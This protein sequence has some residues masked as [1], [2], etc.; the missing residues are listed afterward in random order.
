MLRYYSGLDLDKLRRMS[1]YQFYSLLYEIPEIEKLFRGEKSK[2]PSSTEELIEEARKKGLS[3][4][5]Y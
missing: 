3:V 5:K 1:V 4:P 2:K